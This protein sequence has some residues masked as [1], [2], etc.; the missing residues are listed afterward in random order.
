ME[1]LAPASRAP[2]GSDWITRLD[3]AAP[4]GLG[5]TEGRIVL[6]ADSPSHGIYGHT[7]N[8]VH[9]DKR[10]LEIQAVLHA[11]E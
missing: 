10:V 1:W 6:N 9:S 7:G 3:N 4:D 11:F 5:M 2:I 8:A